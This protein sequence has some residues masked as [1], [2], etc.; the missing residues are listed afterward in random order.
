[1]AG[2]G[3]VTREK[4][5]EAAYERARS[6]G[7]ASLSV[8]AVARDCGVAVGTLYNYFPD[9]ASLVTEVIERFW[10]RVAF[11]GPSSLDPCAAGACFAYREGENLVGF[12]RRVATMMGGAL[13]EFQ[14]G[15]LAEISALDTRTKARGLKAERRCFGHIEANLGQAIANDD[16]VSA[17]LLAQVG[18]GPLARFIWRGIYESLRAGDLSCTVLFALLERAL[19]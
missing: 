8:R 4:I 13:A 11:G 15:W 3:A 5:V 9:K 12:C 18:A 19:Y 6:Q 1:M 10:E 16:A 2:K 7:L 17:E 14:D